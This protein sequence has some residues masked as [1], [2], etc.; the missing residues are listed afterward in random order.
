M[1][2]LGTYFDNFRGVT[3]SASVES[4]LHDFFENSS[5]NRSNMNKLLERA[6]GLLQGL[7]D[8]TAAVDADLAQA[9]V[10][11]AAPSPPPTGPLP[12]VPAIAR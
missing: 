9:L 1:D 3:G 4:A 8:G 2:S 12:T 6:S 11:Q 5:E 10:P 7:A